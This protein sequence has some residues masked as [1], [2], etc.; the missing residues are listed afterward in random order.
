MAHKFFQRLKPLIKSLVVIGLVLTLAF[1]QADGALAA[2]AGGRM[3]GG[4]FR[5]PSRSYAPPTQTYRGP[6]GGGYGYYPGGGFGFPFIMPIFGIGGGFG[7]LFSILIFFAIANFLVRSFRGASSDSSEL[8][9]DTN[10]TVSVAKLQVGLL[11]E[12]R[13]LQE[14]LNRIAASADTGSSDG[15]AQL[16][17]E[18]TLSLLRHPDYWAYA[19]TDDKQTRLLSAEQ[20]FNRLALTERS[21]FTAESLSNINNQ[22]KQAAPKAALPGAG[23]LAQPGEYIVATIVVGVQGK[24]DLPAVNN[25]QDLRRA[26]S[27]IGAVSSDRLLAVEVLWTPQQSGE[28]LTSDELIAEYPDLKLV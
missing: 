19:A 8:D 17:Q 22:L 14:D 3:G 9:Y 26:L 27:Q 13:S 25:E 20:E 6:S 18:T 24:L 12:A 2:R 4:S 10:P 7:G 15:L 28:T 23:D 1:G 11:A 16:L 21:K 5:A